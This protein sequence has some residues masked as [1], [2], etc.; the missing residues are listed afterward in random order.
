MTVLLLG[1]RGRLEVAV[2]GIRPTGVVL[3]ARKCGDHRNVEARGEEL[4]AVRGVEAA[5]AA[6]PSDSVV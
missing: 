3:P 6:A 4:D 2:L 5:A 1:G